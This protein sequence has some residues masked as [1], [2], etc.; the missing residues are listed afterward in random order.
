MLSIDMNWIS[1]AKEQT[2]FCEAFA[3]IQVGTM[4]SNKMVF[5]AW[6]SLLTHQVFFL[7]A[8]Y[9]LKFEIFLFKG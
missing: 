3:K 7:K 6:I 4:E 5:Q 1:I 8:F 2:V 9:E